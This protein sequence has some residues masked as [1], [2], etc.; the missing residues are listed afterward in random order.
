MASIDTIL[1]IRVEGTDQMVRLKTAI[2][3]TS[4]ELKQLK[5]DAK[6]AGANQSEFNAKIL[7]SETKLKGLRGELNRSK[8]DLIKNAK[9]AGDASKSYDSLTKQNAAL[10]AQLRKLA[11]PL[12]KNNKEFDKLSQKIRTNTD[13]LKKMDAQMGRNQRNVGN[14]KQAITSVVTAVGAAIIAF[15]TF[16]RVLGTFVEFEFQM[17][18]VGVISGAT[19]D[20]LNVLTESA[21]ELGATTAFTAGEVAGLQKELAKLGFNPEEIEAMTTATL[22]LAFAFGNELAETGEVVGVV[23][24][25]YKLE[26][27]EA[28]RVTDVLAKAFS[29][30]ALDLQKFSTAF[31]KVGAIAKQL[32]FSFEGT[33]AILGELTNAGLDASVAGTSLK[34]IFL[35]L[36]D[37]GSDLSQRLGGNVKS[38]DELLPA[39]QQLFAEGTDVEE[40]LGLTDKRAVTAFATLV[41][42]ADDVEVL[43]EELKDSAGTAAEFADVMRDSLKGSLDEATSAANGFVIEL[44][45]KLAPAITLIVDGFG[46]MFNG[47]SFL[48]E[49]FKKIALAVGAYGIVVAAT[50]ISQGTFTASLAASSVAFTTYI[51]GTRLAKIAMKAFNTVT[52]ANPIALLISG[53]ILA[54]S[55]F[56]NYSRNAKEA[57]KEQDNLNKETDYSI[58]QNRK[59]NEIKS[60][61]EKQ[62]TKEISQLKLLSGQIQNTNLRMSDR[63]KALKEFNKLTGKTITNLQDERNLVGELE[64]AYN[65]AVQAIKRKISLQILEERVVELLKDQ[66]AFE[67]KLE[68]TK[69]ATAAA[70]KIIADEK[71]RIAEIDKE[72]AKVGAR[73]S[74]QIIDDGKKLIKN[75]REFVSEKEKNAKKEKEIALDLNAS[76]SNRTE[77]AISS[78]NALEDQLN[79]QLNLNK[80]GVDLQIDQDERLKTSQE[81]AKV[82]ANASSQEIIDANNKIGKAIDVVNQAQDE[83]NSNNLATARLQRKIDELYRKSTR[84]LVQLGEVEDET[85]KKTL[86]AYQKLEQ[87]VKK[88]DKALQDAVIAKDTDAIAKATD[89]LTTAKKAMKVVDDKIAEQYG[90]INAE[91]NTYIDSL[92]KKQEQG[93]QNI[94]NDK[95]QLAALQRLE[96]ADASFAEER[97]RL[98]L[99]IAQAELDLALST[100]A[101]SDLSTDAQIA[102]MKRLKEQV[103]QYQAELDG[104]DPDGGGFMK[105]ILF[106]SDAEGNAFTGEDLINTIGLTLQ[107]VNDVLS[108][109]NNLQKARLDSQLSTIEQTSKAEV[110]A[111][112]ES[113]EYEVLTDEERTKKIEEIQARHDEKMLQLKIAQFK[114]D[115]R[116][117]ISQAII[118]GAMAIMRIAAETPKG[119]FGIATAIMIA[120]QAAMTAIQV[121]TIMAQQPPTAATGAIMDDSFFAKGGMVHGKSHAQGGEKFSVGGRVAE[122]E[123][124]E[125]V[126]NKRSTAMF[127]PILS[128]INVAGG[129]KKFADGGLMFG[130][131]LAGGTSDLFES[132]VTAINDQQVLLVESDVTNSQRSVKTIE[133]KISF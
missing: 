54:G 31:P 7:A 78:N 28:A 128:S 116:I 87:A 80:L 106:G 35:K 41:A 90:F 120:A 97:I 81:D 15:R 132:I 124:G 113:A 19:A 59:I 48:I 58:K 98:A 105:K 107:S 1:N 60:R 70:E 79:K 67:E 131:D 62:Q 10:S 114:K 64:G 9:A 13:Q 73:T 112:E 43:T 4:A 69:E 71:A 91:L 85:T 47:L 29:S 30:T 86:T 127:K 6:K 27:S 95:L 52:K 94:E 88:A 55:L 33:T 75:E 44:F 103:E 56:L 115:Q 46:A 102:N 109:F 63:K 8:T 21:K 14:Y 121:G 93:E 34:N 17:K 72:R 53:L 18:Q 11:D 3:A 32:G 36:A 83:N 104:V 16:Q 117:G 12:G 108:E 76:L 92:K 2:D 5:E 96:D 89:D 74:Q 122:L 51:K 125:A 49:N 42:G 129:G 77:A 66:V 37:S 68:D 82:S 65:G 61:N 25:S 38:I 130:S 84:S 126:I 119:D 22:D 26:A 123:G 110:K 101:A 39:L 100:A 133:S 99:K 57:A 118:S 24:N 23:M 20:E 40:M 50:A 45:E 111:F